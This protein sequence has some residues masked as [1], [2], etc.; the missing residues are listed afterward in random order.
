MRRANV[1]QSARVSEPKRRPG[2]EAN[3]NSRSARSRSHMKAQSA[4]STRRHSPSTFTT[5]ECRSSTLDSLPEMEYRR[6]ISS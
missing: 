4:S 6:L 3:E 2:S 5:V 1:S